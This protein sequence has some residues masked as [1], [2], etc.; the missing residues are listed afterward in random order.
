M[1]TPKEL[2]F[3]HSSQLIAGPNALRCAIQE[4]GIITIICLFCA[5]QNL[6]NCSFPCLHE[7]KEISFLSVLS[8][9]CTEDAL[10]DKLSEVATIKILTGQ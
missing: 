8:G 5:S 6:L 10:E 1:I 7:N 2:V 9:E 3:P 4:V